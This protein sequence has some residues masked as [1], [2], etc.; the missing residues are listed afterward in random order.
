MRDTMKFLFLFL[1]MSCPLIAAAH[2][3][4]NH[5]DRVHLSAK[6]Q[7]QVENDT[8]IAAL[9]AQE[10]G[11]D[12]AQLADLVNRRISE[13]IKLIKQHDRIKVQTGSYNTTPVYKNNKITG[14]RVR[15]TIRVESL[16]MALMSDLLGQ[17]QK[18]LAVQQI[19]YTVSPDLKNR[20]DD[21]LIS[22]A[23]AVFEQRAKKITAQLKR[24]NYKI[25][26]IN[27]STSVNH[28]PR[29]LYDAAV[30]MASKVAA[31]AI[32][33]GEQTLAVTVSGQIEME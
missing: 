5:Y 30:P 14:W 2:E 29:R 9:Y 28:Y 1:L 33:S 11:S 32:E 8:V 19:S 15:Q 12:A 4:E 27:I 25:V 22:E 31:P 10:E 18:T 16:D 23:L 17:L 6:A 20:T 7:T 13:A 26:D 3:S 24:K 21:E